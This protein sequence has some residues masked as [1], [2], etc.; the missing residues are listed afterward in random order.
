MVREARSGGREAIEDFA[1]AF[2]AGLLIDITRSVTGKMRGL[3]RLC[4]NE[5]NWI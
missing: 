3:D 5:H 1:R 2:F 4:P